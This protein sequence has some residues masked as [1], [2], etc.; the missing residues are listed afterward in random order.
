M[1]KSKAIINLIWGVFYYQRR[2]IVDDGLNIRKDL[3]LMSQIL[4]YIYKKMECNLYYFVYSFIRAIN[5]RV[6]S[7]TIRKL[8]SKFIKQ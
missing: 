4:K 8:N 1:P 5:L 7:Y 6:I 2:S 3:W